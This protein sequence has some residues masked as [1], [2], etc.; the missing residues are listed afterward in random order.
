M[1]DI[2][3]CVGLGEERRGEKRGRNRGKN[4]N[5]KERNGRNQYVEDS[6]TCHWPV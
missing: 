1:A 3:T 4:G 2:N 5:R 6:E